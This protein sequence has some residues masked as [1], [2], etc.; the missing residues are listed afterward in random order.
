MRFAPHANHTYSSLSLSRLFLN[1]SPPTLL[2]TKALQVFGPYVIH[3]RDRQRSCI[4]LD[5]Y[6]ALTLSLPPRLSNLNAYDSVSLFF[7]RPLLSLQPPPPRT[8]LSL[9]C[10]AYAC[11]EIYLKRARNMLRE[12]VKAQCLIIMLVISNIPMESKCFL[13]FFF[14][15]STL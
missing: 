8:Y 7:P 9:H 13:V 2:I 4:V 5:H 3:L 10:T 15:Y 14:Y 12:H 11:K 1:F 6:P